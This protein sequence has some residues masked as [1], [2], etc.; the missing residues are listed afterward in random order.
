[1]KGGQTACACSA[2]NRLS[3]QSRVTGCQLYSSQSWLKDCARIVIEKDDK[4]LV[5]GLSIVHEACLHFQLQVALTTVVHSLCVLHQQ[6][7][8]VA[9]AYTE[10]SEQAIGYKRHLVAVAVSE[11]RESSQ[12]LRIVV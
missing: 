7:I 6:C 3:S 9:G 2:A 8:S 11:G 5:P 1:P 12:P 10:R 4:S